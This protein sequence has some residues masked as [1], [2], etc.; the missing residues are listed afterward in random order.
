MVTDYLK[1][2]YLMR[3]VTMSDV[4]LGFLVCLYEE[5]CNG[6]GH[7]KPRNAY[8]IL[9]GKGNGKRPSGSPGDRWY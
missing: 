4:Y 6:M 7:R 9:I 8:K 1:K 3:N 2:N 5:E